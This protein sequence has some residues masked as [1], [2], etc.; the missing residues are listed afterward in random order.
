M[1]AINGRDQ[2]FF[3]VCVPLRVFTDQ[4]KLPIAR[5]I[6]NFLHLPRCFWPN[7]HIGLGQTK[8]LWSLEE[9]GL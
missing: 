3:V 5:Q 8:A 6:T 2:A 1:G 4:G 7:F 9:K